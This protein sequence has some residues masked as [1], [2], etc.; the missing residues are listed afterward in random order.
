MR[1]LA[2][3]IGSHA[4]SRGTVTGTRRTTLHATMNNAPDLRRLE[5]LGLNASAPPGQLLYDG[6]LLRLL[7]GQAKRARSVNAL[8]PSTLPL[9]DK[10]RYCEQL[11]RRH[12]LPMVFRITPF[13]EPWGLDAELGRLGYPRFDTTAVES[14]AIDLQATGTWDVDILPLVDWVEAVG[15]LRKSPVLFRHAH[16]ER[17]QGTP[18][19]RSALV[20]RQDGQI[21]AAGLTMVE[22]G[23]AGLF[24]IVTAP[25]ARQQG[26]GRQI[27][28]SLLRCAWDLGARHAYLQVGADN[29]AA[30]QLYA[31]YGFRE[32]YHYWY[33]G[34]SE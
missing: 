19:A 29:T 11:Y 6:W 25:A 5:E 7:P 24:D 12:A 31:R 4:P 26:F 18:L 2:R 33:R 32:R 16:L 9:P 22:D 17:L 34:H 3:A 20:V 27:V 13:S 23:W 1:P 28:E 10:I 30:R 8:Y 15:S 21:V 14:A